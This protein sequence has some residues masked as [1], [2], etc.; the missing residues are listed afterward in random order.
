MAPAPAEAVA[1]NCKETVSPSALVWSP[2][3]ASNT[4]DTTHENV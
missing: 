1:C 4:C 2:G 3:A